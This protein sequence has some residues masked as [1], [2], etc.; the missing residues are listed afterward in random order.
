MTQTFEFAG[1]TFPKSVFILPTGKDKHTRY[2]DLRK[3]CG[4]YFTAPKPNAT[5]ASFYLDSDFMPQ[6]RWKWCD[7]TDARIEHTGWFTDE[8]GDGDKIRGLVMRLPHERGFIAGWSMGESMAS[9]ANSRLTQ[10]QITTIRALA[11]GNNKLTHQQ[12][13]DRF[14]ITGAYVSM[15]VSRKRW[16]SVS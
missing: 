13:A 12:I 7:E 2:R 14:G 1:F 4:P 8:Y 6:L 11:S 15:I 3:V 10:A 5:G 16:N 9:D